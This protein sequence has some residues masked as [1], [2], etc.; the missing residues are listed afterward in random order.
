MGIHDVVVDNR[1]V[2][3]QTVHK[4]VEHPQATDCRRYQLTGK[5]KVAKKW[6][7]LILPKFNGKC[8][9]IFQISFIGVFETVNHPKIKINLFSLT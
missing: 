6:I 4:I 1:T 5:L 9:F 2:S 8:Y 7:H 3:L